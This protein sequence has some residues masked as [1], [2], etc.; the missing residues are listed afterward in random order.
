MC[1]YVCGSDVALVVLDKKAIK[2]ARACSP[3]NI[4]A[5][6]DTSETNLKFFLKISFLP[7]LCFFFVILVEVAIKIYFV[8]FSSAGTR[9]AKF[10]LFEILPHTKRICLTRSRPMRVVNKQI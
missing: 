7:F 9:A 2:E 1:W 5:T 8:V 4:T 6:R 3:W 10:L